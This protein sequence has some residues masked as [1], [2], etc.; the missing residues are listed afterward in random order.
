MST[1][2]P[3]CKL[4]DCQRCGSHAN[5]IFSDLSPVEIESISSNRG[6]RSYAKGEI[7]F[8]A[9]RAPTGLYC[10]HHGRIKIYR[11][12]RDGREQIIRIASGGDIIGYRALIS[13]GS[14]SNF[15][16][17]MEKAQICHIPKHVFFSLLSN[18]IALATRMIELLSEEL[19]MAE[20]KI[21]ELAQKPVRERLAETLLLLRETYGL[22]AD[23]V[24]LGI[25]LTRVEL[26]NIV[27]TTT[28][29]VSRLLS[30]LRREEILR[31]EGRR[32]MI[33][34]HDALVE[35]ANLDD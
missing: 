28:E 27:G 9:G 26:A 32:I 17:P 5:S 15:A 1:K 19:E 23:G 13:G 25:R 8:F 10:V 21:V 31:I 3:Q 16:V 14:Y 11:S 30:K 24:T 33:L 2:P 34:D 12:G 6:C 4:P 7:V 18:N 20:E 29:S 22:D 35:A